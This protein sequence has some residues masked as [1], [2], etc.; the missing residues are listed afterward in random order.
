MEAES[1]ASQSSG[2]TN[3]SSL[4]QIRVPAALTFAGLVAGLLLGL[5]FRDSLVLSAMLAVAEPVG[6]LWLD[7]T[8]GRGCDGAQR[9][10]CWQ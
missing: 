3:G 7:S 5:T 6:N 9:E 8:G 1:E 4:P 10:R 2:Q